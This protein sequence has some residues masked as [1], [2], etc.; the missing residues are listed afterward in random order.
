MG[1]N[2][3]S[4]FQGNDTRVDCMGSPGT[5]LST[6]NDS[7]GSQCST[8]RNTRLQCANKT[9][10][11]NGCI[12]GNI[13]VA[14]EASE[15]HITDHTTKAVI[16]SQDSENDFEM[17]AI[18]EG[19]DLRNNV[20]T[21]SGEFRRIVLPESDLNS[22]EEVLIATNQSL[23]VSGSDSSNKQT[24]DKILALIS[25]IGS[26]QILQQDDKNFHPWFWEHPHGQ[27]M[28]I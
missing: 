2:V 21:G 11:I 13:E 3:T 9:C 28:T 19:A 26:S 20:D 6:E 14:E 8:P 15:K 24:A 16:I 25:E 18:P 10:S 12:E 5:P 1:I 27:V 22:E 17:T 7:L 23:V 4:R